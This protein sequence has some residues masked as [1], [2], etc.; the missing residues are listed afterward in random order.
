MAGMLA[1]AMPMPLTVNGFRL[2]L[3]IGASCALAG[4]FALRAQ[5]EPSLGIETLSLARE[6]L[7]SAKVQQVRSGLD[8]LVASDFA[9]L[10]GKRVGLIANHT[11]IDRRGRSIVDLFMKAKAFELRALFSPEHGF[12]GKLEGKVADSKHSSG[13]RIHSLYGKTRKPTPAMLEGLDC[14]V[15]DIQDIGCRFY[16]YISTMG[17]AMQVAA[18]RG[19]R[20]VVLDRPN[21][22]G[23]ALEGPMLDPGSESFVAWHVLPVRHGMT[24]GE[25]ARLFRRERKELANLELEVVR[26]KNWKRATW[27][28][29]SGLLWVNPSP[30]M[31]NLSEATLYP[32]VGLLETTNISVGRGTDTPFERIGAPWMNGIRLAQILN[33]HGLAGIRCYPIRFTPTTSKH[34]AELC[35]GVA[36]VVTDRDRF[37]S[38]R[39]GLHIAAALRRLHPK[40]WNTSRYP[41]LLGNAAIFA[42]LQASATGAELWKAAQSGVSA[43]V[44]RRKSALLY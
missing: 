25:L 17:N 18:E 14:L 21:P 19:L 34:K 37:E 29:A 9:E 35:H 11:A 4:Q 41:R 26:V 20:F 5:S 16:T 8:V 39:F 22:I 30:N 1:S 7:P 38:V 6:S 15:F 24:V 33:A 12:E 43:F 27:F 32:G 2:L 44:E 10:R 42:K 3:T 23:A 40:D 13:L 36:F 28:D 31:R